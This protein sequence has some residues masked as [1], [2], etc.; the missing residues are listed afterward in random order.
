MQGDTLVRECVSFVFN[1]Y[2]GSLNALDNMD[3]GTCL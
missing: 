3:K 1:M 2:F